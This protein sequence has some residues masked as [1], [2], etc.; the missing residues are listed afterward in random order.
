MNVLPII[1]SRHDPLRVLYIVS[2]IVVCLFVAST[3]NSIVSGQSP[4]PQQAGSYHVYLPLILAPSTPTANLSALTA[5]Y[6]GAAGADELNGAAFAPDGT[7]VVAGTLPG[8]TPPGAS[9]FVHPGAT[10]GAV[11]RLSAN[12]SSALSILRIGGIVRDLDMNT[13]GDLV[14]CGDMGVARL[15]A[16]ATSVIWSASPGDATR[17]AVG[18]D[19]VVAALV[20]NTVFVYDQNGA[21]TNNWTATGTSAADLVVDSARSLVIVGGYTQVNSTLQLPWIRAYAYNGSVRWRS[22]DV[23]AAPGLGADSRVE[24]LAFGADGKLYVAGSINGGIGASIFSRDPKDITLALGPRLVKSD[25][26]SDSTNTGSVKIAWFGRFNPEDGSLELAQGLLTR[27]TSDKKGNSVS[28]R[29]IAADER[30]RVFLAGDAACCI[31]NRDQQRI[32]GTPVGPYELGEGYVALVSEDFR[33]RLVWTPY[34]GPTISGGSSG[35]NALAIRN[36]NVL[37]VA[38]LNLNKPRSLITVNAFQ[39][40]PGGS[41]GSEGYLLLWQAP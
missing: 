35:A 24:R 1:P 4:D 41:T 40:A 26:Y 14:V 38:K 28:I 25:E 19:G 16:D 6:L 18:A 5:T 15:S 39:P 17:C 22:Y 11:L 8:Y 32:A 37:T 2:R 20:G 33:Q 34:A 10:N 13:S 9:L 21:L 29:A 3:G 31:R 36:G 27:R 23:S 12:G 30:G 7:L